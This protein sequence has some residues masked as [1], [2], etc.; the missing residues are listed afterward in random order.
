M[1]MN[2]HPQEN[3]MSKMQADSARRVEIPFGKGSVPLVLREDVADWTVIVP[4]HEEALGDPKAAFGQAVRSPIGSRPL[5][6]LIKP[7]QRVVIVTADGTRPVPNR[8]LIPWI[9][10]EIPAG[11]QVTVLLGTGTHRPNTDEEIEGMFGPEIAG[12][13]IV[14]NHDAY[15]PQSNVVVG[16]LGDG[17]EASLNRTYVEADVRICVGFI[18]PHFFAGFS[19]G[20]KGI[21]PGLGSIDTILNFH[22]FRNIAHPNS[23]YGVLEDNPTQGA[24]REVVALCPPEFLVNVTLNSAKQITRVFA[25][26]YLEAHRR[27]CEHVRK[28]AMAPV[29]SRF[30]IVITSCTGFPLDQNLYQSVKA[31][32]AADRITEDGGTIF[33]V[34]ECSDGFPSHGNF[35][36]LL[37][38]GLPAEEM[39]N[40]LR[41]NDRTVLDQWQVQTL[42]RTVMRCKLVLKSALP[43]EQARLGYLTP[44]DNLQDAVEAEIAR[45]SRNGIR[46]PVAV[47]PDGPLSICY[48]AG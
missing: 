6:E 23:A 7:G 34:S 3:K 43:D 25:G 5:R 38:E 22:N 37:A 11:A 47:L 35:G 27:G 29:P 17:S 15:D 16:R 32:A 48:V 8:Q 28:N 12:R 36:T 30:P 2:D 19:G 31:V 45:R 1:P 44:I 13:G 24:V 41:G 4:R 9:L 40:R 39:L 46:V 33:L 21:M 10:E 42:L 18:E 26:H 14:V 20:P